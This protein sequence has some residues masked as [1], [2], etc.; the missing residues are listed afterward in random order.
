MAATPVLEGERWEMMD[1]SRWVAILS[2]CMEGS[3]SSRLGDGM[4]RWKKGE[5]S[6]EMNSKDV[7][8]GANE[9]NRRITNSL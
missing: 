2:V 7:E 1:P 8:K 6:R 5:G 3:R 4:R 9:T